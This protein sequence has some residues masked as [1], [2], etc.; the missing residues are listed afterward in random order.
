MPIR[1][2]AIELGPHSIRVNTVHP[3]AVGTEML[4]NDAN[5]KMFRPDLKHPTQQDALSMYKGV[6]AAGCLD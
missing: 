2:A 6:R 4:L 1:S 3:T 5:Y